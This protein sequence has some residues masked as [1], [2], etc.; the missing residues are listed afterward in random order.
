MS[1]E[2]CK[3]PING[4]ASVVAATKINGQTLDEV[5]PNV[6]EELRRLA[7][8]YLRRERPEHTLQR[9]A[10]VH[11]AYLRLASRHGVTVWRDRAHFFQIFARIM[12]ETLIN[13]AVAR[14]RKRRGGTDPAER[15]LEFY[16]Q[17]KIDIGA[18]DTALK[19][20]EALDPRQAQI[21]E[22]RFFIGLTVSEIASL[23]EISP[24]TVKREWSTAKIWLRREL[25]RS[26]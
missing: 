19:D 17:R 26:V 6:Y 12:R 7:A 24:A 3:C 16:E 4:E 14:Q 20:L 22:L 8:S 10:L 23:M 13:Y 2:L 18:L 11:E 5:M 21:V 25:S 15:A 9:T 1:R